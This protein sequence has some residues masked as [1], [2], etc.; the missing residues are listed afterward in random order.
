VKKKSHDNQND[1]RGSAHKKLKR[2]KL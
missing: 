2:V 1:M